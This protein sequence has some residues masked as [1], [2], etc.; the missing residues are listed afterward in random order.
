MTDVEPLASSKGSVDKPGVKHAA[1]TAVQPDSLYSHYRG[2]DNA[3][4]PSK[5]TVVISPPIETADFTASLEALAA[6]GREGFGDA[7]LRR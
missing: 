1:I 3:R 4:N 2:F 5:A 6:E 7:D